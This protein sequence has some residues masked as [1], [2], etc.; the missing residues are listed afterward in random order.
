M[1]NMQAVNTFYNGLTFRS[2]LEAVWAAFFDA[3]GVEW[4]YEPGNVKGARW[5][6]DFK[7]FGVDFLGDQSDV[8]AEVKPVPFDPIMVDPAFGKA[9]GPRWA[10]MLGKAPAN[11]FI[12]FMAR[13]GDNGIQTIC[14]TLDSETGLYAA[15]IGDPVSAAATNYWREAQGAVPA[16]AVSLARN[17]IIEKVLGGPQ[18][19]FDRWKQ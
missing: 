5:W 2:R 12:G 10:L 18:F 13:R 8:L 19:D 7:V 17:K 14:I 3:A 11:G 15:K 1:A 16:V 4:E 6:P 9:L